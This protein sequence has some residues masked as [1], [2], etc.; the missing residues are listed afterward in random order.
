MIEV[1]T[2]QSIAAIARQT[3]KYVAE[4]NLFA[5]EASRSDPFHLRTAIISTRVYMVLLAISVIILV[6][7]TSLTTQYEVITIVNPSQAD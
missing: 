3:K 4:L 5:D 6:V 2:M 1:I 7:F